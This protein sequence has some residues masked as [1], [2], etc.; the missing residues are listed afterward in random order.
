ML[1]VRARFSCEPP[2]ITDG[3]VLVI[4]GATGIGWSK[5]S[6]LGSGGK[7]HLAGGVG[8]EDEYGRKHGAT[9]GPHF[10]RYSPILLCFDI[11]PHNLFCQLLKGHYI[12]T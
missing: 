12:S 11:F 7:E 6:V 8:I 3:R 4:V 5:I 10:A 1:G 2:T 9:A